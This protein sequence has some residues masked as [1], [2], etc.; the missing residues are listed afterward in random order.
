MKQRNKENTTHFPEFESLDLTSIHQ[1]M[2]SFWENE[3]IFKKSVNQKDENKPFVFYEGPP[4][5]NGMPGIH[6]V[7]GRTVKDIFCRYKTM[8]GFQV[9]RKGGWDT[10]GL[11]V[12]LKVEK[13][14]GIT[15]EDIGTK[16]SVEE[17]NQA[18]RKTVLE[19]K[20]VWDDLTKKM[21]YWV[22]LDNPYITYD[23]DYI[24]S[25]WW[26]L[27]QL[28]QKD[29]LYKGYTIQPFSPAA[30]TGLS[31]HE[32]N[33]PG[34]YKDVTDTTLVAQFKIKNNEKSAFL[35][36]EN[37]I[38][39]AHFIAWTTTPWTLPSNTALAVGKKIDYVVVKTFNPYTFL[40]VNIV[41][42]KELVGKWFKADNE[43]ADFESYEQGNKNIPWQIIAEYKGA[44][45]EGV[46][47]EQLL[48]YQQPKDGDAFRVILGDFVTTSDGTGIVHIAPSFGADDMK[49]A[50]VAGIGSLTL[51]DKQGKFI[52][53]VGEFSGRYVK[54]Y[55][56]EKEY[57]SVDIDIAIKLKTE[58]KA[59]NVQKHVHNYPHCWR[60]DKPILYYPLDSWFIRTTSVKKDLIAN[61]QKINWK[62]ASTGSGRFGNWLENLQ[63]WN[64]SR[65]RFWG[66]PLPIWRTE[67]GKE[68]LCIGSVAQL[69][70][71]MQKANEILGINNTELKDLHKPYIDKVILVSPNGKA[72][73]RETDVIDV[74]FDSGS[75]PFAQL[76]YPFEN[77]E[78]F[79][80]NYP[81][82][83]IAEGVD[84]TRGW[85]FTLHA[86]STM[87]NNKPAYKNVIANGLVQDAKGQKMSKRYGNTIDPFETLSKYGGDAT[88]WYIIS[89]AMPWENLKFNTKGI[90]EVQRKFFGTLYNTYSFFALYANIDNF[91]YKEKDIAI[92]QRPEI[93]QWILSCLNTLV[94]EVEIALN[95]YEPT[96]AAR[97][98]ESYLDDYLSNWYV[99][100]CRRRFWKGEYSEDK[101]SAYQTLY[102]NLDVLARLIAPIAPF[103]ADFLYK[104]L[105]QATQKDQAE[106]IH[107]A[108]F[109]K[110]NTALINQ[111][112]EQRMDM[113]KNISSMVLSI[114]AKEKLKVRQPLQRILVPITNHTMQKQIQQMEEYILSEVNVKSI[115]YVSGTE[116]I[117]KKEIKPNF[118]T[119][120]RKVG[121]NMKAVAA[122]IAQMTDADIAQIEQQQYA[123]IAIENE[124]LRLDIEDFVIA[125]KDLEGWSV[126][127]NK[128]ITV[129][130][131][132]TLSQALKNEGDA[133]EFVNRMQN[134]RKAKDF[135]VTDKILVK[136][137]PNVKFEEVLKSFKS[138]ICSEILAK[139][140]VVDEIP[141]QTEE[142]NINENIVY[143]N[144]EKL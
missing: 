56:D 68:T 14:L 23:N 99:R 107:L 125:A 25:V 58:N 5:A 114:R 10:H 4:S 122:A 49:V 71:E 82:D 132:T 78:V 62:P 9:K 104:A 109:P 110:A 142:L 29:L 130:L 44:D 52:D 119:L 26:A 134:I 81:A 41:L 40:P 34:A 101:I 116:G 98:I 121:K 73:R 139:D 120:G 59:F 64:L 17:Y 61:N 28:Y 69:N 39:A 32:L 15:K 91:Q 12:E 97:L 16:I 141:N 123:D 95:D 46:G 127:N 93:D 117:V 30:G 35:F 51:V 131:D 137:K 77:K 22:D 86:I 115:E 89:N 65:S 45:L 106:S 47:Y 83:F 11:P 102:T 36:Q 13:E 19:F 21:G 48:P 60:T 143:I 27:S 85:F 37:N 66:I 79:E 113:A 135:D 72:M 54:D 103:F 88:R 129:A 1:Q 2:L 63:D 3:S 126:A 144:V 112:L 20:S 70:T 6:H 55:R 76:H 33:Q 136:I 105:N 8:Q 57:V 43:N 90:E 138:Y 42:A 84:Q 140:I 94:Q 50:K 118:K 38:T 7:I 53:E 92:Q 96:K 67:D 128:G 18:C 111:D 100:L 108:D 75:M 74:W 24:E 80:K 124:T 133:R 31:T 87:L